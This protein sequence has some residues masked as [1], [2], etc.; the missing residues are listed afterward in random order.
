MQ[1]EA[2][3]CICLGSVSEGYIHWAFMELK[4]R[5]CRTPNGNSSV[6]LDLSLMVLCPCFIVSLLAILSVVVEQG[7]PV[8][9]RLHLF[10]LI[11]EK[12]KQGERFRWA[13]TSRWRESENTL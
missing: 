12:E 6:G 8:L 1:S 3:L 9:L 7:F 4:G 10:S 2:H 13:T 11:E 5:S